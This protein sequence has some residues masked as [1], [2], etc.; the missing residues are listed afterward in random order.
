MRPRRSL[1]QPL[2]SVAAAQEGLVSKAQCAA[3]GLDK[4]AVALLVAHGRWRRVVR[5]VYDTCPTPV[6][7]R[8]ADGRHDHLRRR[9]AWTAMLAVGNGIATGACALALLGVDG[10]VQEV[11]P[12]AARSGGMYSAVEGVTLRRYRD[13][14]DEEY[15]GRRI[16]SVVPALAQAL[17][18]LSRGEVVAV[19]S[20]ALREGR[21]VQSGLDDVRA[22]LRGRRG[23]GRVQG[24]VDL[25]EALDGSAAESFARLSFVDSGVPP[26]G[27]QVMFTRDGVFLARVDF[28]WRLLD[29]RYVVAEI[30]GRAFHAGE[31]MLAADSHRQNR[32]V[33]T[34]RVIVIR[35]PAVRALTGETPT[36]G[37]EMAARLS[38][39]GWR[40]T[41]GP[42]N[43]GIVAL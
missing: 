2:L 17:P 21:I 34:G 12:E 13:F 8:R 1:P 43:V 18:Y 16:A 26:D 30:D 10:L 23:A 40:P 11:L 3:A 9:A 25:A 22:M 14:A 27:Q 36:V 4:D 37:T 6:G 19:L 39:L 32:L 24:L 20:G 29:G 33:A 31:L 15:R 28:V 41:P 7:R 38:T 5:C 35:F 42:L